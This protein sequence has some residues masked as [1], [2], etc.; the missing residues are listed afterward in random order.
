MRK[1]VLVTAIAALGTTAVHAQNRLALYEEFSGE[2]CAPCAAS[3]PGLNTLLAAGT[4][5]SKVLLIKYQSPIPSA[6]PIYNAYTTVTNARLSYY[7]VPFAPYGR[8]DGTIQGVGTTSPGHVNYLTQA[9]ID[10]ASNLAA[11]FSATVAHQWTAN[12]DSVRATI[13]LSAL[14]AYAPAG[15]NLKLRVALIEHLRYA[16]APGTNGETEFHNVVREM[17]PNAAGTQ[18]SNA[19]TAGQT[20]T[21]TLKGRV[22][23]YVD[24]AAANETRLVVWIQNDTD[25]SIAFAMPSTYVAVPLDMG[26]T[27][28]S[29]PSALT[30][31]AGSA[32]VT[33]SLTLKNTGTTTVTSARIYYKVDATAW[34]TYNWTGSLAAN[35]TAAVAM[36]ALTV[37]PGSHVI[38]D[39]VALPNG[40]VDVNGGNNKIT[41]SIV[42]YNNAGTALPLS[43]GFENGGALPTNWILFDANAN[44]SNWLLTRSNTANIGHNNSTY[45]LYH[46]NFDYPSG[47]ANYAILPAAV[48]PTSGTKT[49]EF[50]QA[51]AQ[52]ATEQDRL[53]VVYS[54]NCGTTWTSIWNLA[55]ANLATA[56]ATITRF[57]PTQSQ[58]LLRTVDV[59][60]VPAGA[61]LALR[62]TS[63]YG[64]SLFV[65]DITLRATNTTA[66]TN[67]VAATGTTL[68]P[69]PAADRTDLSFELLKSSAVRVD[70]IDAIGRIV[71]TPANANMAAGVQHV[72]I[73]TAALSG[74]VYSVTIRT[75]EGSVTKHL[76]VVH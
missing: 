1:L 74:G 71:A 64:N 37:T 53:E 11:P 72:A 4:N 34:L 76:S 60:A 9:D 2:N 5:P 46:N 61:M 31:A 3:N 22:P 39:S 36:P 21:I 42:V 29:L 68:A 17:Y 57:L 15:A 8:L 10:N 63:N 47:E 50:W 38:A 45:L 24:K 70:V 16:T 73:N 65:D 30:C 26:A 48:L 35:A 52:Y 19:W 59:T 43:T 28:V 55:G 54:T 20:Q 69:N 6:G 33:P 67:V 14:Q 75:A 40:T 56:P 12:G 7:S 58:W 66:V 25:K 41:A 13:N 49:L 44:N 51:Y 62:A 27:Q 18:L 32:S 23:S